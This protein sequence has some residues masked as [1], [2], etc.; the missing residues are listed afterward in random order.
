MVARAGRVVEVV[1]GQEA[2]QLANHGEALAVVVRHE[3]GDA[4]DLV[5]RGGAAER[6]LGDVLVG[7][8]LDD[9]GAGD[10]HVAGF[11]GHQGEVGD[12]GRVDRA[13]GARAEDRRDLRDDAGGQGV[14]QEDVGVAGERDDALLDARAAGVVE[15]DDGRADAH[16]HVHDLDDLRGVGFGERAAED[17]EV[18]GEDEDHAAVDAAVAGDEAVAGDALGVHAEVCR[19]MGYKFVGLLEGAFVEQ[20]VDALA[21]GELAGLLLA[22]AALGAAALFGDRVA[23]GKLCQV[24]FVAGWLR[25]SDRL[26]NGTLGCGHRT[27]F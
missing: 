12:G 7:D 14:A 17:G 13:A 2:E 11:G 23:G 1:R 4:G 26:G 8:G 9:V 22:G 21:G 18:L 27:R 25:C 3:V 20:E 5:V 10:E 6:V 24:A 19:A 16:R 15:A